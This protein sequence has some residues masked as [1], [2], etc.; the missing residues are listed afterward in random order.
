M[1]KDPL[2][3]LGT[4]LAG[5]YRVERF[6][7]EGGFAVVYQATHTVWSKPVALKLFNALSLTEGELHDELQRAF[8]NE[9]ALLTEL[10]AQTTAIVQC[11]DIGTLVTPQGEWLPYLVLEWVEGQALDE[12]LDA[13]HAASAP[14][15]ALEETYRFL[16]PAVTAMDVVHRRGV[17]HRD[18]K[19]ANFLV[20][21]GNAH[22]PDALLKI[23]DFGV[24][25]M[26]LDNKSVQSAL[27][28]TGRLVTAFT[29]HY[30]A[31]EQFSRRHGATGP[32][33]DVY[34][35]ALIATEM[36]SGKPPLDGGDVAELSV[37]SCDPERRPTPRTHGV[38]ISDAVE[39]VFKRALSIVPQER[40]PSAGEFWSALGDALVTPATTPEAPPA[41][42]GR[43][44]RRSA[45]PLVTAAL[46]ATLLIGIGAISALLFARS[47][48]A[49]NRAPFPVAPSPAS[50]VP[51]FPTAP[52]ASP[53]R[54]LAA[55]PAPTCPPEMVLIPAARFF[56]GS[57]REDAS[58]VEKP[59]RAVQLPAYCIDKYETSVAAY[60]TCIDSG[61]CRDAP[62]EVRW[63]KIR[64]KDRVIYGNL[65]TIRHAEH[66]DHP[67][68]CVDFER[69]EAYCRAVAKRL[70]TGVEWEYAARGPVLHRYP[71][72]DDDPTPNRANACNGECRRWS[73]R[74]DA[75][76]KALTLVSD[77]H[78]STAPVASFEAGRSGF[79]LH[80]MAGNVKEWVSDWFDPQA[81]EGDTPAKPDRLR[82]VRGGAFTT[83][84]KE[85]LRYTFREGLA[86]ETRAADV[87]FRCV[88]EPDSSDKRQATE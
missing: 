44:I 62:R 88:R 59:V 42:A 47:R 32:W 49:E 4:T 74:V 83:T 15:W 50:A 7:A 19:P 77:E 46:G 40:Y 56:A 57:D 84:S 28:A 9:G 85:A 39:A 38:E 43:D 45:V 72:G 36:L 58:P 33:T 86:P 5:R 21:G 75:G 71:W 70:P 2:G 27:K 78:P 80:H 20:V 66:I 60:K 31:P 82:T 3:I 26:M 81:T 30:G 37:A 1:D 10:S 17:A 53:V 34:A 35:L 54:S 22:A 8:V 67:I 23:L 65:C 14:P 76:L 48:G 51:A 11:R 64:D 63:P 16:T 79:G 24:A 87:G 29:P 18:L 73:K 61:G 12:I 68:N 55:L 41:G 52:S 25:K 69:A 6:V 13:E